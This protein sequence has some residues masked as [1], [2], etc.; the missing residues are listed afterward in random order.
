MPLEFLTN[1][2]LECVM[3][4]DR[5][6]Y[7]SDTSFTDASLKLP[8]HSQIIKDRLN[9]IPTIPISMEVDLSY[10]CGDKC[11]YCHFAY[12]HVRGLKD[13]SGNYDIKKVMTPE[14]A[15]IVFTKL[16]KAGVKSV[17]FS[18][19]GEPLDSPCALEIF[20]IAKDKGL[21]LGMY[22]RGYGLKGELADFVADNFSWVVVSL[23]VSNTDDHRV[24][25]GTNPAVF[26]KKVENVKS[27]AQRQDRKANISVSLMTD[28][29]HLELVDPY[30]EQKGFFD[31]E[32]VTKLER[33]L[34]WML[35]LGVDQVMT[36][37]IVDTGTYAEQSETH[38]M[39]GLA[40]KTDEEH[41]KNH[42]SWIP[43]VVEILE[44]YKGLPG[45]N[46]SIDKFHDLYEGLSGYG[47]CD[48]MFISAG[49]V[50]TDGTVDKCV[51]TREIIPIGDLKTQDLE[52]IYFNPNLDSSVDGNCRAGCR[53]CKVNKYLK[54]IKNTKHPNFV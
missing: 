51:N 38:K 28:P 12:T 29:R 22:T 17:V 52:E 5:I 46:A 39:S 45:F 25:K 44:K 50:R 43:K 33:D 7:N 19:G 8:H 54:D 14:I 9:G 35:G 13:E 27:F 53:G 6:N 21:D 26:E 16:S 4:K 3:L 47:T 30:E 49:L 42:Y 37:P 31:S 40:F 48:A 41:W 20:K 11:D 34:A 1:L 36:R 10:V 32:K 24:V 15:D 2:I 23:D 18:G